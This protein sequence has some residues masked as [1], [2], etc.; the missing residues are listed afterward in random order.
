MEEVANQSPK[1]E[2]IWHGLLQEVIMR[3]SALLTIFLAACTAATAFGATASD[4]IYTK[5]NPDPAPITMS[6]SVAACSDAQH[7]RRFPVNCIVTYVQ[8]RPTL[9]VE[10]IDERVLRHRAE[11]P[12]GGIGLVLRDW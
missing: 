8:G 12:T 5:S 6:D 3:F 9:A 2:L 11:K 7:G 1:H 10:F 4:T